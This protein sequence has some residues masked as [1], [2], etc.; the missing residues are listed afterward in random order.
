MQ[1]RAFEVQLAAVKEFDASCG[2][3]ELSA[4]TA[5]CLAVSGRHDF[6]DFRTAASRLPEQIAGATHRELDWAG[7]FPGLERPEE[8][9]A[10]LLAFPGGAKPV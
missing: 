10:L 5:R 9:T 7:H 4:V 6:V 2:A 3:V 8:V 1:R